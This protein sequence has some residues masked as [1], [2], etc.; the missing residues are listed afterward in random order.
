M[1]RVQ[2]YVKIDSYSLLSHTALTI[3]KSIIN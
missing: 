1:G 3:D 2:I